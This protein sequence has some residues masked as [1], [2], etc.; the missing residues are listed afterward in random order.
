MDVNIIFSGAF[1]FAMLCLW[2]G[3]LGMA[4]P[5]ALDECCAPPSPCQASSHLASR[6]CHNFAMQSM[7]LWRLDADKD[8]GPIT[9]LPSDM[10]DDSMNIVLQPTKP[11]PAPSDIVGQPTSP[12]LKEPPAVSP[13]LR[14][15]LAAADIPEVEYGPMFAGEGIQTQ[16]DLLSLSKADMKE[17]GLKIAHRNRLEQWQV[18]HGSASG[19]A[20]NGNAAEDIL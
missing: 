18:E 9:L 4:V 6:T 12:S 19:S 17:L 5:F 7:M 2:A 11:V 10:R 13:E 1:D 8:V 3:S 16:G 15:C 14:A 20:A